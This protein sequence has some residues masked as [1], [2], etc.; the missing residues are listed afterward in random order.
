ME[1]SRGLFSRAPHV[2]LAVNQKTNVT[3]GEWIR[4]SKRIARASEL[5][6]FQSNLPH[7][8]GYERL[9]KPKDSLKASLE[10]VNIQSC[11]TW[12]NGFSLTE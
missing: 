1:Q 8:R 5:G 4:Y 2:W 7:S 6:S 9:Q 10:N 11:T 12:T 3:S